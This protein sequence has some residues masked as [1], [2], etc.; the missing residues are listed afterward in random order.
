MPHPQIIGPQ[1]KAFNSA[2][3]CACAY[4]GAILAYTLNATNYGLKG[5]QAIYTEQESCE[6]KPAGLFTK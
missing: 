1:P 2:N 4:C 5:V 6:K 3:S